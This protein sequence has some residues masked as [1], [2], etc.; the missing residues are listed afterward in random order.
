MPTEPL[1]RF[2]VVCPMCGCEEL[3]AMPIAYIA[4]AL[5]RGSVIQLYARCHGVY[6]DAQPIEVEQV[7][8]YLSIAG[9]SVRRV[10]PTILPNT[11]YSGGRRPFW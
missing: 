1:V 10:S 5:L 3:A 9:A 7:R 11:R 8:E 6:W 2:P 4:G